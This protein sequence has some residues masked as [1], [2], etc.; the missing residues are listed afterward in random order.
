[1]P[2]LRVF[3]L[4]PPAI[5]WDD[6]S[7]PVPRRVQRALLFYL[8]AR[9][10]PVP[11]SELLVLFWPDEDETSARRHLRE[12]L[13]KLRASLPEPDLLQKDQDRV[14]LDAGRV[15]CDLVEFNRLN[16]QLGRIP[17]QLPPHT[18]LP[19]AVYQVLLKAVRLWRSPRFLDGANL[20]AS[21]AVDDWVIETGQEAE[22]LCERMA[23]RLAG[24]AAAAGDS[25]QALHWLRFALEI[26]EFDEDLHLRVLNL[27]AEIGRRAEAVKYYANLQ[28]LYQRE[29]KTVPSEALQEAYQRICREDSLNGSTGRSG[30]PISLGMQ[31]PFA[32]RGPELSELK[33]A[34]RRGGLV[35][36]SG[37]AGAGKSRLVR[38][39]FLSLEPAPRLLLAPARPLENSLP[40]QPLVDLLR[41][42]VTIDDW[43]KLPAVWVGQLA[44]L[45]PELL[46][47]RPDVPPPP[48]AGLGQN[49]PAIFEAIRQLLLQ[50]V[51]NQGLLVFLDNAQWADEATLAAVAY[52]IERIGSEQK[53]LLLLAYRPEETCPG[54]AA[55]LESYRTSPVYR[56]IDLAALGEAETFELTRSALGQAPPPDLVRRLAQDT[57]GN[58]LFLLETLRAILDLSLE[59]DLDRVASAVPLAG[60]LHALARGRLN[61]LGPEARQVL[62]VAAVLGSAFDPWVVQ[63][64]SRLEAEVVV[65]ALEELERVHLVRSIE[66]EGEQRVAFIHG[67]LREA[68]LME[69]SPAR[70]Q[71]YRQR[72]AGALG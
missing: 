53:V 38:E 42:S 68:L 39:L 72:V 65:R 7:L 27:L 63:K 66:V 12:A 60:S 55:L 61:N 37:E 1:M 41:H 32:G 5:F 20:P 40:F 26:E 36:I 6:A 11:R 71:L 21:E 64:A 8:A 46:V 34:A 62:L 35:V 30:W 58:P 16:H 70:R 13:S 50:L 9:P 44:P 67:K 2:V 28:E 33:Q 4:G 31:V 23:E 19:E 18:P 51:Q 56:Q 57:G 54:L 49:R 25:E 48:P 24:H 3:L 17:W 52:L 69:L 14:W 45:L 22:L 10:L 15:Y 59:A 43:L 47:L 29:L